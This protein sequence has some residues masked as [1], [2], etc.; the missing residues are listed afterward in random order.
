MSREKE[1]QVELPPFS[2]RG[3]VYSWSV[4]YEAGAPDWMLEPVKRTPYVVAWIKLEEG[5]LVTAMMTDVDTNGMY[6]GMKV[7]MVTRLKRD[8]GRGGLLVYGYMF[9]PVLVRS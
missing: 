1:I 4:V 9:R 3:E 7:E 5:P 6:F 8:M 2:G